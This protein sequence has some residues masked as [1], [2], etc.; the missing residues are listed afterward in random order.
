MRNKLVVLL[1]PLIAFAGLPA[2]VQANPQALGTCFIDSMTGKERKDLVKWIFLSMA[3]H[4][5]LQSFSNISSDDKTM[6][7]KTMGALITRL[8]AEDCPAETKAAQQV[9]PLAINKAFELV[10]KVAMQELMTNQDVMR[11][12]TNYVNYTDQ[13]RIQDVLT[14]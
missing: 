11:S 9:D 12:L 4:P 13:K 10:G 7:D 5:E 8:F 3:T 14:K 2:S 1:F 6:S